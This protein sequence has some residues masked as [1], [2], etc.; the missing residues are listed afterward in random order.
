MRTLSLKLGPVH[1]RLAD[2]NEL[3]GLNTGAL[4]ANYELRH[5]QAQTWQAFINSDA[6][7]IFEENTLYELVKHF[8][9][10]A[11]ALADSNM[12]NKGMRKEGISV[13]EKTYIEAEVAIKNAESNLWGCMM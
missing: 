7:V 10:D 2:N 8:K 3:K 11:I 4:P 12:V 1:S 13:Q 6:N 9:N 5:H